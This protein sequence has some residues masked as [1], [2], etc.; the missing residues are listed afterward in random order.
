MTRALLVLLLHATLCVA[1]PVFAQ[2]ERFQGLWEGTMH[3]GRGDQA[4]ALLFRPRGRAGFEGMVYM[5]GGEF[6]PMENGRIAGD[7]LT[8]SVMNFDFLATRAR[9][10]LS[11]DLIV[12]HGQTHHVD[13]TLTTRDTTHLPA[14]P[15]P[16][17]ERAPA[18]TREEPPDS[19]V[20]AHRVPPARVSSVAPCLQRGTL[21]L[22]GGGPSQADLDRRF[23]ELAG[24]PDARVVVI[25][26]ATVETTDSSE[27]SRFTASLAR[28]LGLGHV[29]ALHTVSR[30]E[31]DSEAFIAPLR[32]ATGVWILGG[33]GSWLLDSYLGTRT[34]AELIALLDRGGVVGG[35]S[36]G[37]VIWGSSMMVF[38]SDGGRE[39]QQMRM[40]NLLIGDPHGTG[41]GLLRNV[42]IAPHLDAYRLEPSLRKVVDATPGLLGIGIDEATALEIHGAVGRVLGRGT[43]T[44]M[45]DTARAPV[46]LK[47]GSRYDLVRRAAP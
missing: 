3:G 21:L 7:T 31:A 23:V 28:H 14:A 46:V 1:H 37:A 5:G 20:R 42:M 2:S 38:R 10:H 13:V 32:Q 18:L 6:G 45:T 16:A 35:T 39:L 29:T 17:P 41:I 15:P 40:E 33:E 26:T 24:G 9:D 36:A 12:R 11:V 43:V 4:M 34:E 30:R 8:F 19:V 27:V 22:V 47:D 25:P 44:I